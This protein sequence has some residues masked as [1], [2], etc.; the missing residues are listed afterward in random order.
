VTSLARNHRN[1]TAR[2]A[3]DAERPLY[4]MDGENDEEV[5]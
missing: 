3:D 5:A 1:R 2:G 4:A